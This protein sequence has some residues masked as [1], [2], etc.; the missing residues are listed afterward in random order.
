MLSLS[1]VVID[2]ILVGMLVSDRSVKESISID[3]LYLKLRV[4]INKI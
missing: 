2:A 1:V 4:I 3:I